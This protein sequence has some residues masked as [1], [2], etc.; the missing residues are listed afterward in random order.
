MNYF[1]LTPEEIETRGGQWTAREIVQQPEIWQEV[2]QLI[3]SDTGGVAAFLTPLLQRPDLR[4][5]LTGAGT[6]SFIGECLAPALLKQYGRWVGAVATTDLVAS[7]ENHFVRG[8]PTLLVSFARSGNSPE[9]KAAVE[10]A[11]QSLS[12]CFH[13]I[14]T[15][16][17]T[18]ELYRR[19]LELPNARVLLLPEKSDDRGFAMTSS[20][21]G[22][23][24]AAARFFT[25]PLAG[26]GAA[27]SA[28]GAPTLGLL[29][30]WLPRLQGLVAERFER[31]VYLGANELK[32]LAREAALKTLELSDGR[33]VS[34]ADTPLGFRH[35][36]KTILNGRT[37]VVVLL[38]NDSH[39]RRYDLDLLAE[40]RSDGIAGRVLAL[41]ARQGGTTGHPDDVLVPGLANASDLGLCLPFVVFAQSLAFM[42][43]LSLG[44]RPD[45]P[46][47]A[48]AVSRVV[49][50]V[51]IYPLERKG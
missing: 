47:A 8:V 48:G 26:A 19:G 2:E 27:V 22:M 28:G 7:P 15:C 21:S 11:E 35:G 1:G 25:L 29:E 37:L 20:F 46:N 34:I 14:V 43:S 40:L 10:L 24:L 51:S 39:I 6:S 12:E 30:S 9:S 44:I 5:V 41:V 23:L 16:N 17:A 38:S 13:L 3:R 45:T 33:V 49:K 32:G 42:Q 50:G 18:G 4:I 36:P 31:I